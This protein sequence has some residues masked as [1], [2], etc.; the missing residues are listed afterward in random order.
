[1]ILKLK[2]SQKKTQEKTELKFAIQ[3]KQVKAKLSAKSADI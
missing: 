3:Q 2:K 1:M